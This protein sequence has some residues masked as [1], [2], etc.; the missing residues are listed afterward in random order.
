MEQWVA[1][2]FEVYPHFVYTIIIFVSFIEGPIL[3]VFCG[4][5]IKLG[6][7]PFWP[8][9]IAL[10]AG[11]LLGD[12]VWYWVGRTFGHRFVVRFG[13][14]V[15]ITEDALKTVE[16]L[17]HKYH[18]RILI[19]S[20]LTMGLGFAVATLVTAGITKV[21]FKR[22]FTINFCCQ[23]LWTAFLLFIGYMFGNLYVSVD[24]IFGK[25]SV[26]A[27]FVFAFLVLVGYG[28]YVKKKMTGLSK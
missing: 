18:D 11:D 27:L 6:D 8:A 21:P 2:L 3:A 15:S 4:L 13:H 16:R 14:Y 23:F 12:T 1:H 22:Y 24:N 17:F 9:Y 26:A 10:M 25:I 28:K 5:L 7:A 19:V 20:K